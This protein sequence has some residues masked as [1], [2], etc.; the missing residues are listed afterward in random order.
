MSVAEGARVTD[1]ESQKTFW[2]KEGFPYR[3]PAADVSAIAN[4]ARLS[5]SG[6]VG[7]APMIFDRS[8]SIGGIEAE[9]AAL[10]AARPFA[11][12]IFFRESDIRCGPVPPKK[13]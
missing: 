3:E 13:I 12:L 7:Q 11:F 5:D 2:Y 10:F 6:S 1:L 4:T 8:G 9:I